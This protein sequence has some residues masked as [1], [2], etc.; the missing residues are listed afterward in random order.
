MTE[1][2]EKLRYRCRNPRCRSKLPAP[3]ANEREAFCCRGRYDSFYLHRCR[4]CEG[5]IE[6]GRGQQRLICKKAKCKSVWRSKAG[7]GRFLTNDPSDVSIGF[8][9]PDFVGV[10]S[11]IRTD[12]PSRRATLIR[13][14]VQTEFFGGWQWREVI[15]LDGVLSYVT[16]LWGEEVETAKL[17]A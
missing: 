13:N 12:Q 3:V 5:P 1:F 10:K 14:A 8:G 6:Q 16:R 15:S 2:T 4:V 11:L 17:A 7:F 9:K